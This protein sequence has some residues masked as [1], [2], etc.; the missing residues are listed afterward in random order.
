MA[1]AGARWCWGLRLS[2][3]PAGRVLVGQRTLLVFCFACPEVWEFG[4][5]WR[6]SRLLRLTGVG[7]PEG[8]IS[9]DALVGCG[10]ALEQIPRHDVAEETPHRRRY[11]HHATVLAILLEMLGSRETQT[12]RWLGSEEGG[13]GDGP[14]CWPLA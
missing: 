10:I 7:F 11:L 2:G 8:L 5:S 9:V 1:V 12:Q 6:R 13:F 3:I 4:L 14:R